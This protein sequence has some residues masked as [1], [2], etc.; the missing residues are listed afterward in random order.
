MLLERNLFSLILQLTSFEFPPSDSGD[1]T[2]ASTATNLILNEI[3]SNNFMKTSRS[4]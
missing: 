3:Q 4:L 2:A 1:I